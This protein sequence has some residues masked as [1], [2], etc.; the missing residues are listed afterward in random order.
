M[1]HANPDSGIPP[2]SSDCPGRPQ[3]SIDLFGNSPDLA[4]GA[5]WGC[6][7]FPFSDDQYLHS[8]NV[9]MCVGGLVTA[10]GV[11]A[12]G[13]AA[14]G[15]M[16][17]VKEIMRRLPPE[18]KPIA[19]DIANRLRR[20]VEDDPGLSDDAR[21][22]IPQ[23]IALSAPAGETIV[24]CG[25][26]A[27]RVLQEMRNTL[28][29]MRDQPEYGQERHLGPFERIVGPILTDLLNNPAIS[30]QLSPHMDRA[31]LAMRDVVDDTH[32]RVIGVDAKVDA[33]Q[34][35]MTAMLAALAPGGAGLAQIPLADLR[36][37]ATV[38]GA[39]PALP[40]TAL[41]AFLTDKAR[42]IDRLSKQVAALTGLSVGI[43][44]IRVEAAQAV[45]QG[46]LDDAR[47][48][49]DDAREIRRDQLRKQLEAD[50]ALSEVTA[51]IDLIEG[52][53]EQ[54]H[55]LL[56]AAADSFAALDPLETARR[57]RAAGMRLGDH[58]L[59]YGGAG[60]PLA[61]RILRRLL[62][63]LPKAADPLLWA[64]AQ[65]GLAIVLDWQ[66]KRTGGAAGADMLAQAVTAYRAVLEVFTRDDHPMDW[67]MAMQNLAI[68]LDAQGDSIGGA[69][70]ATL[71][72]QATTAYRA[73]L[74][75]YT[76]ADHPVDWAMTM[77]NLT[78][79]LETQGHRTKGAAGAGLLRQSVA[80]CREA[81]EVRTRADHPVRWA[82]TMQ[83]LANKLQ[84]QGNRTKGAAG[85][86]L[87]AQAVAAFR[88]ALEVRTRADHPVDWA[89]TMQNL[90]NALQSQ[91]KRTKRAAG[92]E[93]LAQAVAAYRAALEV[94]NR[95]DR[96]VEWAR[97]MHNFAEALQLQGVHTV[98]AA[99]ADLLAEA[100]T[101]NDMSLEVHT[102]ADHPVD[103]ALTRENMALLEQA[104]AA[105]DTCTDPT[106][107]LRTALGHVQAALTVFDPEHMAFNHQKAT[108][109][110]AEIL[111]ALDR[112]A[113]K[114]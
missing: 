73:A 60:L 35:Q 101:V 85:A 96:P 25:R 10:T 21:A 105:H 97:T 94:R 9:L 83:N 51:E 7:M 80:A 92:V 112:D 4:P 53:A 111:A 64:A 89:T 6:A 100:N 49:L 79:T 98:G 22:L 30:A 81:L 54:A 48:L 17:S 38:F 24:A 2:R 108:D 45:A 33:L 78:N 114:D 29:A 91:G 41:F 36:N 50:A 40:H 67:A 15:A 74:E 57:R 14:V 106:P 52:R 18:A 37:L 55:A 31:M 34:A 5:D 1:K 28:K 16:M 87:L 76:R 43:D 62:D 3:V 32:D 47:R 70:G 11:I 86:D 110:K 71:L 69:A 27:S 75:V 102:R 90:G 13:G 95:P 103:W 68:T 104:R 61:A 12:V 77:Q 88:A 59:R 107:H 26:D 20:A 82:A 46:R 42:D 113:G 72:A 109:L 56:S 58:A 44:N 23:M 8:A 65:N 19:Q 39:E 84:S 99:G 93:L 66:G 63:D